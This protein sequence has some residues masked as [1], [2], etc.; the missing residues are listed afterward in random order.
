MS[1]VIDFEKDFD[2][3][4]VSYYPRLI[5]FAREY[6]ISEEDAENIVQDIFLFLWEKR[7]VL[8]IEVSLMSYMFSLVKHRCLDYLRHANVVD[9]YRKELSL[10]L[11]SLEQLDS[12][13]PSDDNIEEAITCAINKLPERCRDVFLK[14]KMEG[15]KYREIASEMNISVNTVENQMSI[16]LKKLRIELKDYLPLLV[17]L[18]GNYYDFHS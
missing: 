16:A 13:I 11:S 10:K 18:I 14:C 12:S 2:K 5:R 8:N 17:F 6:V 15:K 7:N 1:D 9:D 3:I 4:Y